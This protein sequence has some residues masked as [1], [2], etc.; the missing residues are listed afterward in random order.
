MAELIKWEQSSRV[1]ALTLNP[2]II[3]EEHLIESTGNRII[4]ERSPAYWVG[5]V[6]FGAVSS[7]NIVG[8]IEAFLSDLS[9]NQNYTDMPLANKK[10][11]GGV[12]SA[13][14]SIDEDSYNF[15]EPLNFS[16]KRGYYW[17]ANHRLFIQLN[18]TPPYRFLPNL[19]WDV[20]QIVQPATSIRIRLVGNANLTTTPHWSGGWTI[21]FEEVV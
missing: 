4:F 5:S 8:R 11:T 12:A 13:V 9:S 18:D 6:T 19:D 15:T 16:D 3:S 14:T 10:L 17:T 21:Q 7:Q 1:T 20:G 2:T